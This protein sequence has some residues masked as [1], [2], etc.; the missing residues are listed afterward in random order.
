[1]N[2]GKNVQAF[3]GRVAWIRLKSGASFQAL[4]QMIEDERVLYC[5]VDENL[6]PCEPMFSCPVDAIEAVSEEGDAPD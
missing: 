3:L 5:R 4:L 1:M 6:S 2:D